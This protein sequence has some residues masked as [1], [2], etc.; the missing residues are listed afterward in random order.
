[1]NNIRIL[2][3]FGKRDATAVLETAKN[4]DLSDCVVLGWDG[5]DFFMSASYENNE[6][7]LWDLQQAINALTIF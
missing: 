1:M 4:A 5:E 2:P 3:G 7:I 6:K